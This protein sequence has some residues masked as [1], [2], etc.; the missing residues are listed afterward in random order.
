MILLSVI[1][2]S[3]GRRN[4]GQDVAEMASRDLS[5]VVTKVGVEL[6]Y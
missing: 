6:I 2:K 3:R 4:L 1:E 5:S